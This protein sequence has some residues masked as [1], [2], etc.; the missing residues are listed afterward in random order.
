MINISRTLYS[1]NGNEYLN[2]ATTNSTFCID[3]SAVYSTDSSSYTVEMKTDK[4]KGIHPVLYF[5]YIK[6]KFKMIERMRIDNRFKKLEKAFYKAVDSGQEALGEKLLKTLAIEMR[7][8][9]MYA[10]GFKYYIE[11]GDLN[12][13]KGNIRGGH[14]SDTRLKDFTRDIPKKDKDKYNASLGLFDDYVVYHYWNEGEVEKVEKKEKMDPE[15][16]SKMRDPILFGIIKETNK[17]YF[18]EEW[19]DEYCD[20][21]FEELVDK[22]GVNDEDIELK[23][24]PSLI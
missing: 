6:K 22:I 15:E 18:I 4:Q 2:N 5:K 13:H 8:T 14:I 21:T 7:E 3:G 20:L 17:L 19:E 11:K 9:Q 23:R 24:E 10:K 1:F 16:K 12:K